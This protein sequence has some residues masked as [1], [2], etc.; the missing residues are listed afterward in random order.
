MNTLAFLALFAVLQNIDNFALGVAYRWQRIRITWRS[1]LFIAALSG[2]FTGLAMLAA[3]LAKSEVS[4][5]GLDHYTEIVGRGLLVMIG[6]WTLIGYFRIKLFPQLRDSSSKAGLTLPPTVIAT[7]KFSETV[8]VGTALAADN[9]AP[10]FA[11]GLVNPSSAAVGLTLS[12]LTS[13]VSVLSVITGQVAGA[14]GR[15]RLPGLSPKLVA[16]CLILVIALFEPG[17]LA[18]N[19]LSF[20]GIK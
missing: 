16:G 8:L 6:T 4:R 14:Q 7:M 11:F 13:F 3:N 5:F 20:L 12:A 17:D 18:R 10:S 2:L 9:L 19:G 1:N 15:H